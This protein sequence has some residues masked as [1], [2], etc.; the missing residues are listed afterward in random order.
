[1]IAWNGIS[2]KGYIQPG[3]RLKVAGSS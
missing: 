2:A 3:Q 1:L